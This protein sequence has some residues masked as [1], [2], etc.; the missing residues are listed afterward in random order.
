LVVKETAFDA[1]VGVNAPVAQERPVAP[2]IFDAL[3]VHFADENLFLV[4]GALGDDDAERV[5]EKRRAPELDAR[6]AGRALVADAVDR[7]DIDAVGDGVRALDGAP[8]VAL[9]RA[10]LIFLVRVP[11]DGGRVE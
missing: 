7:R 5:G 8:R 10:E 11:A 2:H 6:T 4:N 3:A 1:A 9:L